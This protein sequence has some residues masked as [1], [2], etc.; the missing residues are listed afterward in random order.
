MTRWHP[1]V[2]ALLA[3]LGVGLVMFAGAE[4]LI[5]VLDPPHPGRIGYQIGRAIPPLAL[6]AAVIGY[7]VQRGRLDNKK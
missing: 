5:S 4:A 3:A 1:L 2:V 6:V 7:Y